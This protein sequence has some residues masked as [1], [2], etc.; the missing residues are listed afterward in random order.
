MMVWYRHAPVILFSIILSH[1]M[2]SSICRWY[3]VVNLR[4]FTFHRYPTIKEC[5]EKSL[6][7]MPRFWLVPMA[8]L[9]YWVIAALQATGTSNA[10]AVLGTASATVHWP[11]PYRSYRDAVWTRT[12][13]AWVSPRRER[14]HRKQCPPLVNTILLDTTERFAGER[15]RVHV[16][17]S[18]LHPLQKVFHL[19][20]IRKCTTSHTFLHGINLETQKLPSILS[21]TGRILR[22]RFL[23]VV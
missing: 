11:S 18:N 13:R 22:P 17:I 16:F 10:M 21:C 12:G 14:L 2:I 9:C 15:D 23:S 4:T 19:L 20:T 3:I 5:R 7:F 6:R 1:S 8:F